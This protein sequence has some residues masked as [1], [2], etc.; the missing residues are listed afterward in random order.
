M[1]TYN[2]HLKPLVLPEYG[3]VIQSMVDHCLTIDD[4]D[5]K[6]SLRR[7]YR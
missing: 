7:V 1:L 3:R 5:E 2:T 6:K 4:R